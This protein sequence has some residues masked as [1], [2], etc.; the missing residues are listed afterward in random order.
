[1]RFFLMNLGDQKLILGYPWFA[2]MQPKVDWARA[3]INYDQ[4]LVV[5]QTLDSHKPIFTR[6]VGNPTKPKA[7]Q[8]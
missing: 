3:W 5:L 1:M 6:K 4:L 8:D 7:D 2:T